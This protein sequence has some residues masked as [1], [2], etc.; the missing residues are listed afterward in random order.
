MHLNN[1]EGSTSILSL[2]DFEQFIVFLM[3]TIGNEGLFG[4][5]RMEAY[6]VDRPLT[7]KRLHNGAILENDGI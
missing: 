3:T 6:C 7:L 1:L 5:E 4:T 2:I